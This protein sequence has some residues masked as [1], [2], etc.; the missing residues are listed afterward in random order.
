MFPEVWLAGYP[1]WT[2]GWDSKLESWVAGRLRFFDEAVLVPSDATD[3]IAAAAR[4]ANIH[5]VM[6][7]N[8]VDPRPGRQNDIQFSLIL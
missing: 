7:C 2:E 6:G 5:V 3:A 8:E 1:F 4:V